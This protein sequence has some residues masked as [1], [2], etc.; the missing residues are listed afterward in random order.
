MRFSF[1]FDVRRKVNAWGVTKNTITKLVETEEE[2]K[3]LESI[4]K[5]C[6]FK[7]G[8]VSDFDVSCSPQSLSGLKMTII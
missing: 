6:E 1:E 2:K 5:L 3:Q 8:D 4:D 7:A